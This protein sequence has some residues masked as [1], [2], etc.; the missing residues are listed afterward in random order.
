MTTETEEINIY[1]KF[2]KLIILKLGF[3][4]KCV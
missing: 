2:A 1:H 4:N 3:M